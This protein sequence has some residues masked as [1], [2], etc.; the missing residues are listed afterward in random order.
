MER[1][2]KCLHD[3]CVCSMIGLTEKC[4][5]AVEH[6]NAKQHGFVCVCVCV[7]DI[8]TSYTYISVGT[9]A[10][11]EGHCPQRRHGPPRGSGG[12]L[13]YE[14]FENLVLRDAI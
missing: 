6:R 3:C 12:I 9:F 14:N 7:G 13:P 2:S 5:A 10:C 4:G 11:L 8:T 1:C